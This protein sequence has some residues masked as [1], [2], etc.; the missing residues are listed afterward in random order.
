MPSRVLYIYDSLS[1]ETTQFIQFHNKT[2]EKQASERENKNKLTLLLL[3]PS[4]AVLSP[5]ERK[6]RVG[7]YVTASTEREQRHVS[8]PSFV[9]TTAV[10]G[11]RPPQQTATQPREKFQ[12]PPPLFYKVKLKKVSAGPAALVAKKTKKTLHALGAEQA[13]SSRSKSGYRHVSALLR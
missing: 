13:H 12:F 4:A 5:H 3:L 6:P 2:T 11:T 8:G 7:P 1:P 9:C 10:Q